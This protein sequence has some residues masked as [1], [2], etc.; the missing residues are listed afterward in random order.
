MVGHNTGRDSRWDIEE[1]GFH[2]LKTYY[3]A[4]H[5][6]C[7]AAVE[8]IFNLMIIGF[9]MRE[10]YLYRR[11]QRFERSGITRK[12]VSRIFR[13][14]LLT[15]KVKNRLRLFNSLQSPARFPRR[16][17]RKCNVQVSRKAG[18]FQF[19]KAPQ[20]VL[21]MLSECSSEN[22]FYICI[23]IPARKDSSPGTRSRSP[24]WLSMIF[25]TEE[26][27]IP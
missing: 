1:N 7:H 5:C 18:F 15:E 9:N 6:Y 13:D 25:R 19:K 12:S 8:T 4:K 2:Q 17:V 24:P 27:P 14:D 20:A 11:I 23:V 16:N 10:L 3:H 22:S 21:P 26:S